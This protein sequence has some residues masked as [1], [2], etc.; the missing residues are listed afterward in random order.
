[1]WC[2]INRIPLDLSLQKVMGLS[3]IAPFASEID[4]FDPSF[5]SQKD[6]FIS[7]VES[8]CIKRLG[9]RLTFSSQKRT[10]LLSNPV[11]GKFLTHFPALCLSPHPFLLG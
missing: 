3:L 1:M 11:G 4:L 5:S 10:R 7:K 6:L 8:F 2:C 9:Y